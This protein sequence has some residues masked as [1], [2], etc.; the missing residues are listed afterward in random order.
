MKKLFALAMM[1]L[2]VFPSAAFADGDAEDP[3]DVEELEATALDGAV[4]LQ[5]SEAT[6]DT[7]VEGYFV[8]YGQSPVT[9]SGQSYDE[10]E[11]VDDVLEY[12]VTGLENGTKYYF[13]VVAYD[14]AGNESAAW[15]PEA[16]ATPDGDAGSEEDTDSPQVKEAQAL[17]KE[18]VKLVFSEA[19]LIPSIDAQDAFSIENDDNFEA[20]EVLEAEM[21][22][23]DASGRTVILKTAEQEQDATYKLTVGVDVEDIAG[24]PIISGTSDTAIFEGSG[25]DAPV[26]DS[27]GPK[28]TD[29][30]VVDVEH[31]LV[32][33]DEGIVLSID[34]AENFKFVEKDDSSATLDVLKVELS[35]NETNVES[36]S[37]LI[38]T[39]EQSGADYVLTVKDVT[40]EAGNDIQSGY[41]TIEFTGMGTGGEDSSEDPDND[42]DEDP[43]QEEDNE[44]P[45]EVANFIAD[46]I[47]QAEKY[48]VTLKWEIPS[49]NIEDVVEQIIYMSTNK[50]E[51]YQKEASLNPGVNEYEVGEF[52][53]GDYWFKITQV[54]EAGNESEGVITKVVLAE[55]GPQMLG[56]LV[57]SL[58]M[59]RL[60]GRKKRK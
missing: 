17:Y 10:I 33:F 13:S 45:S 29:I 3:S 14:A 60:V 55:T 56:L 42:P 36:A 38:K 15:A 1:A 44:A 43:D 20:L 24:N 8:H 7:G 46:K 12:T 4:K 18:A 11:D 31:V 9:G 22:E 58:G 47:F 52:E 35:D 59:G 51:S 26:E 54:D 19:V 34:P 39:N 50:G 41:D 57:F 2:L 48:L 16:E 32:S 53:A 30:E 6:D 40:D 23:K 27:Q 21:D 28:I 5:W 25:E 49:Q 37:A